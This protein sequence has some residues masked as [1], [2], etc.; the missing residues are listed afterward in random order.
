VRRFGG[1]NP[2]IV[3]FGMIQIIDQI[4]RQVGFYAFEGL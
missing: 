3:S 2:M 4:T 1:R